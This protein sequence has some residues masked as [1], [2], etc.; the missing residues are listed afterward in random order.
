MAARVATGLEGVLPVDKP[1]GMTSHDVVAAL[2]RA[3]GERRIGHAGTLDPSATGL[4]VVLIGPY[5]RLEPYLSKSQKRYFATVRFGA[6][7]DTDDA[8]GAVV[9]EA[10]VPGLV[11]DEQAA[12]ET[13]AGLIGVH[14]QVPPAY[15]AIKR[16]G[17]AA[18]RAARCGSPLALD[19]RQVRILEAQLLAVRPDEAEWDLSLTVS[20][21]TYVRAI[22]RDLGRMLGTAAHLAALRR[23]A[24]GRIGLEQAHPLSECLEA[25][26]AGSIDRLFTDPFEALGLP[27]VEAEAA[28]VSSGRALPA[29][30]DAA[31]LVAVRADGRLAALYRRSG[32]RLAPVAV[33][34]KGGPA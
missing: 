11:S 5:T 1:S 32:A 16:H 19:P 30:A 21:G 3:T 8:E 25:A 15:S 27:V 24:S 34:P 9:A 29:P 13:V 14:E 18:H 23:T 7:T 26:A 4:L 28:W 31:D 20:A 17:V 22:A 33:F 2:R 6:A 12:R 10:P